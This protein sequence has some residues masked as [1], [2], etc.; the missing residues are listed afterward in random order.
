MEREDITL[1]EKTRELLK[2]RSTGCF[3]CFLILAD[4]EKNGKLTGFPWEKVGDKELFPVT[5][6]VKHIRLEQV[7]APRAK[8]GGQ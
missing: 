1:K 2:S 4:E 5:A 7:S 8:P 6:K 3:L